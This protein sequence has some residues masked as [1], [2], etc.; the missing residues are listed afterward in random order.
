MIDYT[1]VEIV[2]VDFGAQGNDEIFQNLRTLYTTVEGTVPLDPEFGININ[3]IDDPVPI[4]Q[5]KIIAEYSNKTRKFEPRARVKEVSFDVDQSTGNLIPKV[6]I[7][8]VD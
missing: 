8:I 1:S 3:F 2:N 7:G 6:V 5:G 4:A